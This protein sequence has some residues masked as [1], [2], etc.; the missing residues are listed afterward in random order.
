M[1][2]IESDCTGEAKVKRPERACP[3]DKVKNRVGV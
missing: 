3:L 1:P 2:T